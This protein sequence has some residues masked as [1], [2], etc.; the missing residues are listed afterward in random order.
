MRRVVL[1]GSESTGKTA[2]ARKLSRHFG[3]PWAPEFARLYVDALQRGVTTDDVEAIARGQLSL[4]QELEQAHPSLVIFDTDLFSTV[5]Y[6]QHYFGSVAEWIELEAERRRGDLYLLV[7]TDIPWKHDPR[8]R[9]LETA[10]EQLQRDFEAMIARHALPHVPI[11]GDEQSRLAG[12]I[13][14]VEALP[15]IS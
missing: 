3:A 9:G 2:L 12:A 1:I 8:Q 10:R 13:S 14:A 15:K 7:G 11:S 5:V 6:A 4:H